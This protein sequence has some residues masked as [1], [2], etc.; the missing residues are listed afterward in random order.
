MAGK[1]DEH[2]E[3]EETLRTEK[4]KEKIATYYDFPK[5]GVIFR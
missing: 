2:E 4:I 5:P 3:I 1:I